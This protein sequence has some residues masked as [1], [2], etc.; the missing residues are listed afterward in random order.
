LPTNHFRASNIT[1]IWA[2]QYRFTMIDPSGKSVITTYDGLGHVSSIKDRNDRTRT[3][4]YDLNDKLTT[5]TWN[6]TST[7]INYTYDKVGNLLTSS[8]P[9]SGTT[10]V[11]SYNEIDELTNTTYG[12]YKFHYTYD[13]YGDLTQRQDLVSGTQVANLDYQYNRNHQLQKLT[14][15]GT[16]IITQNIDFAHDRLSQLTQIDLQ[17]ILPDI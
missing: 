10:N 13:R 7:V 12:N 15:M 2:C 1:N 4:A 8:D 3:F 16:G 14:A 17:P 9:T 6:G 5:E 11:Y